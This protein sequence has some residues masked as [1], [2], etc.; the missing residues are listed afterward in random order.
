MNNCQKCNCTGEVPGALGVGLMWPCECQK[1]SDTSD[2]SFPRLMSLTQAELT[3]GGIRSAPGL[4]LSQCTPGLAVWL[5]LSD[6]IAPQP[7]VIH[8]ASWDVWV[9][10]MP[11]IT[12][13]DLL[14]VHP[15]NLSFRIQT[16]QVDTRY[17]RWS[18]RS[19]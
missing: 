14:D 9:F 15:S 12:K 11:T 4:R 16:D 5:Q 13:H 18:G 8:D 17:A 2:T 6:I 19:L 3:M 1:Q 10:Y 7:A